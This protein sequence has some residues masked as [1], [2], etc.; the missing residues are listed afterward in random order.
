MFYYG[1][2]EVEL[3]VASEYKTKST[4]CRIQDYKLCE[5]TTS[6]VS[7]STE[8]KL[9]ICIHEQY[10]KNVTFIDISCE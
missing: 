7:I 8:N 5:F 10:N 4:R 6:E 3:S 2:G 9:S 1:N